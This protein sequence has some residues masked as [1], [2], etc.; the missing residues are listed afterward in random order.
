VLGLDDGS[1]QRHAA[2]EAADDGGLVPP[3]EVD[4]R[5]FRPARGVDPARAVERRRGVAVRACGHE[6]PAR[7]PDVVVQDGLEPPVRA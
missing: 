3:C 7:L 4:E 1:P 5:V 6:W 2:K